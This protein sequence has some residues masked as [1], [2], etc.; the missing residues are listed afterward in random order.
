MIHGTSI[1]QVP[2]LPC[3]S[4]RLNTRTGICHRGKKGPDVDMLDD[5][6]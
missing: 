5:T 1:D 2:L 4:F 3:K 6:Q